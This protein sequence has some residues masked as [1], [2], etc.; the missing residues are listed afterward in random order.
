MSDFVRLAVARPDGGVS[1]MLLVLEDGHGISRQYTTELAVSELEKAGL[2]GLPFRL[3]R[4]SDI[5]SERTFRDAWKMAGTKVAVDMPKAVEIQK[6][7]LRKLRGDKFETLDME[8]LKALVAKDEAKVAEIEAQK[9]LL[10]DVTKIPELAAAQ[11][12][13]ELKLVVPEYLKAEAVEAVA[14]EVKG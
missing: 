2:G 14:E 5:P 1:I 7:T 11:T 6:D 8:Q 12:P 10:R 4:E 9:Q 13:D 3:V